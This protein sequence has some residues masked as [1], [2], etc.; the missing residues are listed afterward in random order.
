MLQAKFALVHIPTDLEIKFRINPLGP[1][2][3]GFLGLSHCRI[4]A[5]SSSA[6]KLISVSY[7]QSADLAN[8]S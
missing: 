3:K 8:A 1:G 5:L 6:F 7:L 2:D 4:T